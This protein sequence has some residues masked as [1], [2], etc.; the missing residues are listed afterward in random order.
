MTKDITRFRRV[1]IQAMVASIEAM[2]SPQRRGDSK[3]SKSED[4]QV[5]LERS[6]AER[7]FLIFFQRSEHLG[8][9]ETRRG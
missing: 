2:V 7:R 6:E 9:S 8:I 5:P 3:M 1:V 4:L